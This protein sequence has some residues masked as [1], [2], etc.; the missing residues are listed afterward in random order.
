MDSGENCNGKSIQNER[1]T[2]SFIS[3]TM[4]QKYIDRLENQFNFTT[5][6]SKLQLRKYYNGMSSNKVDRIGGTW[7][8]VSYFCVCVKANL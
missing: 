5:L 8:D 7:E 1:L 6:L 4:H 3:R 2:D